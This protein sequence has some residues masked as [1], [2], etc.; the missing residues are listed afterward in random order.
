MIMPSVLL[1]LPF[2]LSASDIIKNESITVTD[3]GICKI[4]DGTFKANGP[5]GQV[6]KAYAQYLAAQQE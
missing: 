4:E 3:L 6:R 1:T 5:C 2:G